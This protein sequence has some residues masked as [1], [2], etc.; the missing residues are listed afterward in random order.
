M[1]HGEKQDGP[2][3]A[4]GTQMDELAERHSFL[5]AYPEQSRKANQGGYWNWFNSRRSAG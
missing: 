2:D 5:V 1:L 4:A 3:F